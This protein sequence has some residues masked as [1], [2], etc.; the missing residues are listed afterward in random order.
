MMA[1]TCPKCGKMREDGV[2][3]EFPDDRITVLDLSEIIER[4]L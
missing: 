2:K 3:A 1:V 4:A